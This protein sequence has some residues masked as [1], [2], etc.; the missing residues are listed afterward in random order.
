M[1]HNKRS[2]SLSKRSDPSRMHT[3]LAALLLETRNCWTSR[4]KHKVAVFKL[5]RGQQRFPDVSHEALVQTYPLT[6]MQMSCFIE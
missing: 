1:W 4:L 3:W 2:I 6:R 5:N